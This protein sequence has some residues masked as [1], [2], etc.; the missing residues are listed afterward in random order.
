MPE[1]IVWLLQLLALFGIA[2]VLRYGQQRI[3]HLIRRRRVR[4]VLREA[5]ESARVIRQPDAWR[6]PTASTDK[7]AA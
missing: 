1:L 3:G 7:D 2:V 6:R 4:K 5:R